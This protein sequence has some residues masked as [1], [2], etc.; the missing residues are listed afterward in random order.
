M[1]KVLGR[2]FFGNYKVR[3][4][5]NISIDVFSY[6]MARVSIIKKTASVDGMML[7]YLK[8]VFWR[9]RVLESYLNQKGLNSIKLI[10]H[11]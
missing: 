2:F 11:F 6:D 5:N 9:L 8:R 10:P 4:N 1:N 7:I 3:C